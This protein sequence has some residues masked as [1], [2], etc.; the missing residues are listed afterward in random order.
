MA[1]KGQEA[2]ALALVEKGWQDPHLL[3][4]CSSRPV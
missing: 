2:T 1:V 3:M 4:A